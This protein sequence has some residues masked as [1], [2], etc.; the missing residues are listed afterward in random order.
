MKTPQASDG[1]SRAWITEKAQQVLSGMSY[2]S[3]TFSTYL[4]ELKNQGWIE[5]SH[6]QLLITQE[7]LKE[8]GEDVGGLRR[9]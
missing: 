4:Y 5:D 9:C 7:G 1:F 8:A 6:G 3:G 2:K